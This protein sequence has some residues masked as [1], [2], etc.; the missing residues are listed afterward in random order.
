MHE[1]GTESARLGIDT[2]WI[3]WNIKT[4][5]VEGAKPSSQLDIY[6][7]ASCR[8]LMQLLLGI[9]D[10]VRGFSYLN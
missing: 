3:K 5:G 2:D 9:C 1:T 10:V 6:L 7:C 4:C 8:V